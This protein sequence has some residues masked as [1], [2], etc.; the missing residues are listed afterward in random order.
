MGDVLRF[1]G[2]LRVQTGKTPALGRLLLQV[3]WLQD[4]NGDVR[5]VCSTPVGLPEERIRADLARLSATLTG[6]KG[7]E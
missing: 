7:D 5:M 4:P 3:S 6:G 2:P 1:P